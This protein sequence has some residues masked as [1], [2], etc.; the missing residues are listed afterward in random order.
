MTTQIRRTSLHLKKQFF[1]DSTTI[2]QQFCSDFWRIF[3]VFDN[4][5]AILD[6]IAVISNN[7]LAII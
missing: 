5:A 1:N 3:G 6:D 7:I 4:I 2:L